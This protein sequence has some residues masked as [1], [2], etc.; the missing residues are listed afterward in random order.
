M[1]PERRHKR[2]N[3][4]TVIMPEG[5]NA[6]QI[7]FPAMPPVYTSPVTTSGVSAAKVVATIEVPVSH[8]EALLPETK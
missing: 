5:K 2:A 6:H 4:K 8:Q 7:Q 1:S 3:K